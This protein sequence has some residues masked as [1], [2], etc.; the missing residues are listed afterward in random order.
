[1]SNKKT[2]LLVEDSDR[3]AELIA[4]AF[5]HAKINVEIHRAHDGVEALELLHGHALVS[6]TPSLVLLDMKLPRL[7]GKEVL[8]KIKSNQFTRNI[9]VVML[10]SSQDVRDI[11]ECYKLGVNAYVVKPI[12]FNALFETLAITGKF[13]CNVNK[14]S[15]EY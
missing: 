3:D 8:R 13:W 14:I 7:N 15:G 4:M 12:D 5:E 1:M 9:P 2:I 10:T 11:E 6:T